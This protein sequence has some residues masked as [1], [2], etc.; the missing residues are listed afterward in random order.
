[1]STPL[2]MG[3]LT[4]KDPGQDITS[5]KADCRYRAPLSPRLCGN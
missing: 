2:T 3:S 1:M 4:N 5:A